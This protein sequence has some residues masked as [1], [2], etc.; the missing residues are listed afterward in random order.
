MNKENTLLIL[1]IIFG[2]VFIKAIDSIHVV[3]VRLCYGRTF[4]WQTLFRSIRK[5]KSSKINTRKAV[6][7][8]QK[9]VTPKS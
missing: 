3:F 9:V 8:A 5:L 7:G 4:I 2:F 6:G 1:W